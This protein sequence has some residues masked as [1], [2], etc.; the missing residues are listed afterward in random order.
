MVWRVICC[1]GTTGRIGAR[2]SPPKLPARLPCWDPIWRA[3]WAVRATLASSLSPVSLLCTS[4]CYPPS[5]RFWLSCTSTWFA[6]TEWLHCLV[7]PESPRSSF[8]SRFLKIRWPSLLPLSSC[9]S[10]QL[11]LRFLWNDWPIP[12]I[13][14]TSRAQTGTFS[15][16]SKHWNCSAGPPKLSVAYCWPRWP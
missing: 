5:P 6:S 9:L 10:W 4:Y 8:L 12:R 11:P 14:V 16:Y 7:T 1:P 13:P 3:S 2:W 15:F